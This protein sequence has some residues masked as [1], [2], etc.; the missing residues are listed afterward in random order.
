MRQVSKYFKASST[1]K[2]AE[3]L[4]TGEIFVNTGL[5]RVAQNDDQVAVVLAHELAHAFMNHAVSIFQAAPFVTKHFFFRNLSHFFCIYSSLLTA[6]CTVCVRKRLLC[7]NLVVLCCLIQGEKMFVTSVIHPFLL[8]GT[9]LLWLLS[10]SDVVATFT[11][12]LTSRLEHVT[13]H[14]LVVSLF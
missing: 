2:I 3:F 4:Q 13:I 7:L 12:F 9:F 1:F 8:I 10:G 11:H 6:Q 5:L 14:K